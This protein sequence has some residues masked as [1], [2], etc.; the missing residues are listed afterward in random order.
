MKASDSFAEAALDGAG[1]ALAG[2]FVY[3]FAGPVPANAGDALDM[4]AQHTQVA[5]LTEGND[6]TTALNFA[7]ASG[8]ILPKAPA[9]E[10]EG[11]VSFDGA[12]DSETTLAPTFFRICVG[13]DTGRDASSAVRVQ[14][15]LG[16]PSSGADI[17]LG[18]ASLTDNGSNTV[19][20]S[21][22]YIG[23]EFLGL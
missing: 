12:E 15:T 2:C 20:L 5:R 19:G 10:W 9:E 8:R 3:Y 6:G 21:S 22:Y 7:A 11:T 1:A 14:G 17:E 13:A 23:A 18:S 16:G 4:V